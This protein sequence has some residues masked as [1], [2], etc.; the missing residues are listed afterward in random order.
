MKSL[1]EA[2]GSPSLSG[3]VRG[4]VPEGRSEDW[5]WLSDEVGKVF[6]PEGTAPAKTGS[7]RVWLVG[8]SWG[9][10]EPDEAE[11]GGGS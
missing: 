6:Q 11:V 10:G 7:D 9:A 3:V 5:V 4:V 2:D 1:G 8:G